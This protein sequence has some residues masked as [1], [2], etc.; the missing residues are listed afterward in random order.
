M[1]NVSGNASVATSVSV[2]SDYHGSV[3]NGGFVY[4]S[5]NPILSLSVDN[6]NNVS[7]F[8]TV[9][10]LTSSTSNQTFVYNGSFTIN[11]NHSNNYTLNYRT[12]SSAGLETW[13]T[14]SIS[15]DADPPELSIS[16]NNQSPERYI[17]NSSSYVIS[18][19]NPLNIGCS[20]NLSG[21]QYLQYSLGNQSAQVNS[22]S[23]NITSSILNQSTT[24]GHGQL[25]ISCSDRVGNSYNMTFSLVLDDEVPLLSVVESGTRSG[26]CVG[27]SWKITPTSSDNHSTSSVQQLQQATWVS[28]PQ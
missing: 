1:I 19:S 10:R 6:P 9:Y 22:S 5:A 11:Q 28:A 16:S 25:N 23:V 3:S 17:Y 13:N 20:D 4:T 18:A 2:D 21:V 24:N 8:S 12:N 7:L 14:L 27:A 15:V 26:F